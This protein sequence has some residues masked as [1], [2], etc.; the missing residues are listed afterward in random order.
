M[1]RRTGL[2]KKTPPYTLPVPLTPL[3][4]REREVKEVRAL[5][6]QPEVRLLTLTGTGGVG[7]TRLAMEVAQSVQ[8]EFADGVCFIA[9]TAISDPERVMPTIARVL[10]LQ[11]SA[12]RPLPEQLR[13]YLRGRHMLLL[14]D[15]FEQV[16]AA[17]PHLVDLLLHCP[18]LRLMVTSR[19]GLHL[20]GEYEYPVLPLDIPD[21]SLR[22]D[23]TAV[24]HV[25]AVQ[26]FVQRARAVQST[27]QLTD[28]YAPTIAA[29]CARLDGLP[30]AIELAAARIKLLPP[31]ALLKRLESPLNV[32]TRGADYLPSRQQTIRNTIQ[33]SYDLLDRREQRLFC[34]CSVFVGGFTLQAVEAVVQ[35]LHESGDTEIGAVLEGIDSLVDKSLLQ[36][37]AQEE[38]AGE[39]RL[40]MLETVRAYGRELLLQQGEMEAARRAHATFFLQ[41][42]EAVGKQT[43]GAKH[44]ARDYENVRAALTWMLEEESEGQQVQRVE[45]AL[46]LGIALQSFWI[47]QGHTAEGWSFMERMLVR[48]EGVRPDLRIRALTAASTLIGIL[49]DLNRSETLLA[50]SLALS[51]EL[52]DRQRIAQ[53]LRNMAYVAHQKGDFDRAR[54]LY[55]ESLALYKALDDRQGI[56]GVLNNLGYM[57]QNQ[58]DFESAYNLFSETLRIWREI[59]ASDQIGII[60]FLLAQLLYISNEH[61]PASKI[62]SMLDESM[63]IAQKTGD[64]TLVALIHFLQG[65]VAFHLGDLTKARL[66]IEEALSFHK[67]GGGERRATG[68][69]MTLLARINTAQGDYDAARNLF[70]E[71]LAIGNEIDDRREIPVYCLEGMA[72]LAAAQGQKA[73]AVQLWGAAEKLRERMSFSMSPVERIPYQHAITA[74]RTFFGEQ[75][76]AQLWAEGRA[77]SLE[78]ALAAHE[79]ELPRQIAQPAHRSSPY[80]D[81]LSVRE[82]EVLRL[83]AQGYSDA[84]IAEHLIISVRTVN[85]HLT[86]IY[87]KIRVTTRS[88][89]TRYAAEHQLI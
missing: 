52:G 71:S 36:P 83:L 78:E 89:A 20:P 38:A 47:T 46:R 67:N 19:A 28:G 42:A 37:P 24:A 66:L 5:L 81:G 77:M 62:G 76:F 22:L 12:A 41:F 3:I 26:L 45:M 7:K 40:G 8:N 65:S 59:E 10:G 56:A 14:L 87:R 18:D 55:G 25:A 86:S 43:D 50:Q 85:T 17:A 60:L 73:W 63:A 33:W 79:E 54:T 39:P 80:P 49:G 1:Q 84:R 51:R 75:V 35:V 34:L 29:I 13:S 44:L 21:L 2:V 61:P 82:V 57:A 58:R 69:I 68:E 72:E 6:L 70:E 9:L 53:N 11:E 31:Q 32:L 30:L 64:R 23:G 15:N 48:G 74:L 4:G 27:F 16:A 88:A